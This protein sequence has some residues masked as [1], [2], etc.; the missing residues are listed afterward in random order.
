MR[1][2]W[3]IV[4]VFAGAALFVG[5]T[6]SGAVTPDCS[7]SG[8]RIC[9]DLVGTPATV[10]PSGDTPHYVKYISHVSN[11]GN[12]TATHV[13]AD[14]ELTGG[15]V[16]DSVVSSVGTCSVDGHP[17]CVLGRLRSG[18]E[19]TI[20]FVARTPV[21]EGPATAKL[22]VSFDEVT[23]DAP[24]PD[25][26][27]DSV[28]A[29]EA[30]TIEVP[31]GSA[32]SFVP[33]GASVSLTTDPTNTGVASPTDP[34]IGQAIITTSPMDTTAA[35][36]EVALSLPCPKKVV[37]RGGDWFHADIPG[38]FDPPLAFPLRW[39]KTLIPSSLNSKKFALLY[40]ECQAGCKLEV[41]STRCKSGMPTVSEVPCISGVAKEPD[42]D[43]VATLWNIHNGYMH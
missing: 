7:T 20:E 23:N 40:T 42:G 22:T 14:V 8:P 15:L 26:K 24:T 43:W 37:C 5:G 6:G 12:Q 27:Q 39:D 16:L 1:L 36:D 35:I 21:T 11:E 31:D 9:A 10:A 41:I 4:L 13:T 32:A 17:T 30:T 34:L 28:T 2:R 33:Q 29:S 25:P 19:A 18:A 38:T 3:L